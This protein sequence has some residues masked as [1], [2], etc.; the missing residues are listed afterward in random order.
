M[1]G[2]FTKSTGP[3]KCGFSCKKIS[4]TKKQQQISL[5]SRKFYDFFKGLFDHTKINFNPKPLTTESIENKNI[6]ES[7]PDA[8]VDVLANTS[9]IALDKEN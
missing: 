7:N 8:T 5:N 6:L 9:K 1:G 3:K 2:I 4:T